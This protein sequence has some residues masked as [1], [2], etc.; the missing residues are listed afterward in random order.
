MR[1]EELAVPEE[2]KAVLIK[3]GIVELYPPQI[4]AIKLA[5]WKAEIL[6]WPVRLLLEK[7]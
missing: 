1:V 4:E 7:L 3:S 2:V 5:H 6:F